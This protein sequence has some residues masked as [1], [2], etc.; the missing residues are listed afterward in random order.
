MQ[1]SAPGS[2]E[3]LR[4]LEAMLPL[5]NLERV[6]PEHRIV[7]APVR[8]D[9]AIL[10]YASVSQLVQSVENPP[11]APPPLPA[12]QKAEI[13]AQAAAP[14]PRIEQV[15]LQMPVAHAV[16]HA[17]SVIT[18]QPPA[19]VQRLIDV[20]AYIPPVPQREED[21]LCGIEPARHSRLPV[22]GQ[23]VRSGA[24]KFWLRTPLLALLLAWFV[25]GLAAF[26][27]VPLPAVFDGWALGFLVLVGLGFYARVRHVRF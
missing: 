17:A 22:W 8:E 1:V 5:P 16:S 13:V 15:V 3:I 24:R 6:P 11:L 25:A 19:Q 20:P 26:V 10:R 12:L 7:P 9:E 21:R 18:H 27:F 23:I 14:T 2:G 4:L